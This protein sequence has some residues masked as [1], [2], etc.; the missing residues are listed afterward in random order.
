[1]SLGALKTVQAQLSWTGTHILQRSCSLEPWAASQS[2]QLWGRSWTD[3][4][5]RR[6]TVLVGE[7]DTE[8]TMARMPI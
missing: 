8:E 1:M 4:L 7:M 3:S 5:N 6:H 2:P